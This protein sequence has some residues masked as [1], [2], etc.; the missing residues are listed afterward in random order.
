MSSILMDK[1]VVSGMIELTTGMHIGASKD[2]APIGAVDSVVVRN[3]LNKLPMITGSSIKGK[4]RSM[5]ARASAYEKKNTHIEEGGFASAPNEDG[6]AITRLFGCTQP[7]IKFSRLQFVDSCLINEDEVKSRGTDLY[8]TEI[9]FENNINRL[10]GVATPRQIER[11]PAGSKFEL[12]LIY[13][14]E[15]DVQVE[16]DFANIAKALQLLQLDY[17]GGHGSRGYGRIN[18]NGL[19]VAE[20]LING[21]TGVDIQKLTSILVAANDYGK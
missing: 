11:V 4:M 1:I 15:D 13:N 17:I 8:L 21:A 12:K 9:K 14:L 10:T 19:V 5:L 3:P 7:K 16:E 6:E 18:I 2:F 20:K